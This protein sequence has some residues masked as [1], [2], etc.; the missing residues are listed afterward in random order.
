MID[1][2]KNDINTENKMELKEG[3]SSTM[4]NQFSTHKNRDTGIE[5]MKKMQ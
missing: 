3:I 5:E 2:D 1:F 4:K